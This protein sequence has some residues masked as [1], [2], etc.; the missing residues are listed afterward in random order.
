[1]GMMWAIFEH[2][3]PNVL[4]FVN[5]MEGKQQTFS[6]KTSHRDEKYGIENAV[7]KTVI[8]LYGDRQ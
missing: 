6:Y 2:F 7:N 1:M 8:I 3:T 5:Q 4:D